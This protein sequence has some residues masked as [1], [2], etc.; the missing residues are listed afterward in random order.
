MSGVRSA[1]RPLRRSRVPEV[2]LAW[3]GAAFTF[4]LALPVVAVAWLLRGSDGL[5]GAALGASLVLGMFLINAAALACV[6]RL[7]PDILPAVSFVG[8]FVR[9][10]AYVAILMALAGA[11]GIDRAATVVATSLLL[12]AALLF[13]VRVATRT[14]GFNWITTSA[15]HGAQTEERTRR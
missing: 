15:P 3:R 4:V 5:R 10:A 13:E 7:A 12:F 2:G 14:P 8:A 11:D 6:A 1:E 9:M